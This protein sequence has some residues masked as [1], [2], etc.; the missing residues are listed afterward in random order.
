MFF[1]TATPN[2]D[3]VILITGGFNRDRKL[4]NVTSHSAE[5]FLPNSP[6]TPCILPKLPAGYAFHTQDGGMI[7]GGLGAPNN[8]RRWNSKER[9]FSDKPV[10]VFKTERFLH[11]S[12]TPVSQE[13]T[14]LMGGHNL[15]ST[16]ALNTS[17]VVEQGIF[18]GS[19]NFTLKYPFS[20]ACSIPDPD[21][22]RVVITGGQQSEFKH[23]YSKKTSLYNQK[24]FIQY[25]G[26]LHYIRYFHGCTSYTS[27]NKRVCLFLLL[28]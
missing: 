7:C 28:I 14:F 3:L 13:E 4:F 23:T 18:Q 27:D 5:I 9:N 17:T 10:H 24:G 11:V 16:A 25:L 20:G 1:L 15:K 2:T 22:D 26:D 6:K 12:W 21:T 19:P 8:C